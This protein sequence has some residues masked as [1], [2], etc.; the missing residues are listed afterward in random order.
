VADAGHISGGDE[1]DGAA[2]DGKMGLVVTKTMIT[3]T[4]TVFKLIMMMK[5]AIPTRISQTTR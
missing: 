3:A 2:G 4:R 1:A 5:I